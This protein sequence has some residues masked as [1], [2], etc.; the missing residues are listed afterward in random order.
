MNDYNLNWAQDA[1][2][3][4]IYPLG[5]CAAPPTN[6]FYSSPEPRLQQLHGWL[7]HLESLGV[8]A[9]YLGPVFESSTHGYDTAD[10]YWV[11]RRLGTNE[12]LAELIEAMHQRGMR[13]ILDAVLN[14]TGRNFWA[15]QDILRHG[16][17]SAYIDWF[18]GLRF[19]GS[20]PFQDP[21]TYE[22]WDGHY[23]LVKLNLTN[24]AVREHLLGA[25]ESWITQFQI[26]GLRLDA[27]DVMDLEFL[28]ELSMFCKNQRPDFWLMGEIVHG[29]YNQW[30]S[31]TMLDSVTNYECYK[32]L[33]SSHNDHNYYEIAYALNRQFGEGGVYQN[34]TLYA[35]VDNHDVNRVASMLQKADHL[36]PLYFLL[37]TMPGVPSI[38]YGSEWGLAGMKDNGSDLPLRPALDLD[39]TRQQVP[40]PGLV[41]A[42][43]RFSHLRQSSQALRRGNYRQLFV[44]NEQLAFSRQVAD[45]LVFVL[46]NASQKSVEVNLEVNPTL[47]GCLIDLLDPGEPNALSGT[48]VKVEI[49]ACWGRVLRQQF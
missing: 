13:V 35:F 7:D 26:D 15:F 6:D 46:I 28:Q 24:P 40:Q 20:T 1:V 37:F 16:E 22:T 18:Q 23:E 2:F 32:G 38:Y 12:T 44:D 48:N 21:F 8:T 49:P 41:D 5:L 33:Y 45:E 14:H 10:Y 9:V 11:D 31:P 42:I 4:H 19:G 29:D 47:G 36:Y 17:D 43:A 25:V 30:V 34:E 39:A 3:Y 27:A